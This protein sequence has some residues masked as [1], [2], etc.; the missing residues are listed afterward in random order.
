MST[1]QRKNIERS[2]SRRDWLA[3]TSAGIAATSQSGWLGNLARATSNT[4]RPRS[5]IVLWMHGGAS[6]IDTFDPKPGH[7]NGGP[8][9]TIPTT[10][11]GLRISEHLPSMARHMRNATVI[12]SMRTVEGDHGRGAFHMRSGYRPTGPIT[13]PALGSLVAKELG[14]PDALLPSFVSIAPYQM[15]RMSNGG[16]LGPRYAPLQLA[17]ANQQS[18]EEALQIHN[19]TLRAGVSSH[20]QQQRLALRGEMEAEFQRYL[21]PNSMEFSTANTVN[22]VPLNHRNAYDRAVR[23]MSSEAAAAFRLEEETNRLRDSYGRNLFGQSCLLARRLVERGVSFVEVGMGNL[24]AVGGTWDTHSRNFPTVSRL[25]EV[26]DA[27]WATLLS[28]L[29]D[30]GLLENTLVVWMGEFGRTPRINNALGRDH[31]PQA[32]STVLSGA[33]VRA[34]RVYGRTSN[35]GTTVE[36]NPVNAEDFVATICA[37]LQIDP[38][39]QNLSNVGR[40]IRIAPADA[41]PVRGVLA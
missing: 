4:P 14:S 20:R 1:N 15:G 16:F 22:A 18:Y 11:P 34:G 35:D 13:F 23:L 30:R 41:T 40:P 21:V 28:D 12:R 39:Q 5:C 36:E 37:A 10:L 26:L 25:S 33:G 6:H 38:R 32:W 3:W 17:E 27:A 7:A 31:Y 29:S 8:F 19:A 9:R 24:P 2:L